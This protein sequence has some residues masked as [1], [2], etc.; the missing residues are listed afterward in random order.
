MEREEEGKDSRE[1]ASDRGRE[2]AQMSLAVSQQDILSHTLHMSSPILSVTAV[3][4]KQA[5]SL[6]TDETACISWWC[7]CDKMWSK[8]SITELYRV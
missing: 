7:Q 6:L 3:C 8:L 4:G 5:C 2:L 1:R